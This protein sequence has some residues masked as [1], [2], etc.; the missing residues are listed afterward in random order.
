MQNKLKSVLGGSGFYILAAVCLLA[1]GVGG[2]RLLLGGPASPEPDAD[3]PA[4]EAAA[5]TQDIQEETPDEAPVET[6]VPQVTQE[7]PAS[8]EADIPASMPEVPV[9]DTPVVAQA[10]QLIVSPLNGDVV[11]AFSVDELIYNPTLED[12]RTH[13]GLDIFAKPGTTV[14]AACSGTVSS[15][16]DDAMMGTTVVI[17]HDGGYQTTYA[18]LQA[19]PTVQEGDTVSAGEIIGA[20][21]TT[22]AAETAQGP[23]LHFGVTLDGEAIDPQEFLNS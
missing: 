17:D 15:I 4:Q 5:P 2:Y 18:N 12:W 21:G 11:A 7:E 19:T 16:T 9:D 20:V 13:D 23:H 3:Q 22:A 1:V 14:L 10:P 6:I 8:A